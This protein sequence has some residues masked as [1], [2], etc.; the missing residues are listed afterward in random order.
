MT[1]VLRKEGSARTDRQLDRA[2]RQTLGE[3]SVP[4][5]P[6]DFRQ[7]L[8]AEVETQQ[9]KSS[10]KP[11]WNR[12]RILVIALAVLYVLVGVL[13]APWLAGRTDGQPLPAQVA[14][15]LLAAVIFSSITASS[16]TLLF[17][18]RRRT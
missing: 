10:H 1:G 4:T 7:R 9:P 11:A 12:R 6:H 18:A 13:G 17:L 2:V 15:V 14:A 8:S 3:A 5:L 16:M